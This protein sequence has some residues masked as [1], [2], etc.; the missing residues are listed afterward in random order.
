MKDDSQ[1]EKPKSKEK[2]GDKD[3]I[4]DKLNF[5][6][7][8]ENEINDK[9]ADSK[10]PKLE[11]HHLFPTMSE[12]LGSERTKEIKTGKSKLLMVLGIIVGAL[13]IIG[14]AV[15][16]I[17]S[18][19]RIADNVVFGEREVFSVFLILIGVLLIAC[20]IA[21]RFLGKSFFKEIDSDIKSYDKKSSDSAKYKKE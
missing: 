15:M 19:D 9:G 14:G 1:T 5:A 11:E 21:Y 3:S 20:S 7:I 6:P 12:L 10:D 4:F 16:M 18:P 17:G 13:F 8:L 2:K